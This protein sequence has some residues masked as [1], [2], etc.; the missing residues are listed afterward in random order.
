[1]CPACLT[2]LALIAVGTGSAGSL[3][4]LVAKKL[5][6]RKATKTHEEPN[7]PMEAETKEQ[8]Q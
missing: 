2:S 8:D 5:H 6:D 3:A 1:M 7:Q 4:A